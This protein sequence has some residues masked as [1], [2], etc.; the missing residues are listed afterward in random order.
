[1]REYCYAL[2]F[3]N[4]S[5]KE[6]FPYSSNELSKMLQ[7]HLDSNFGD[8]E[9]SPT[10]KTGVSNL[11][12]HGAPL[13]V[14]LSGLVGPE[15]SMDIE[16]ARIRAGLDTLLEKVTVSAP[17]SAKLFSK[18][19]TSRN[20]SIWRVFAVISAVFIWAWALLFLFG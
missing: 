11:G 17:P 16:E 18:D 12:S 13:C 8:E 5:A 14:Q 9:D 20:V 3:E 15:F 1:M 19:M 7:K 10:Y 6:K 4:I 2:V